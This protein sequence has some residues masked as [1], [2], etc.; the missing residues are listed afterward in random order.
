MINNVETKLSIFKEEHEKILDI[1]DYFG[2]KFPFSDTLLE[3]YGTN[4]EE[5][6][7]NL[8]IISSLRKISVG[9]L[10]LSDLVGLI[11]SYKEQFDELGLSL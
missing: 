10:I 6:L 9:E 7:T 5:F 4:R 3:K 8:C 11:N 2:A 1:M